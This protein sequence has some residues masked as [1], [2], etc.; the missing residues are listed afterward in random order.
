MNFADS[1][2]VALSHDFS[3]I[4]QKH[5]QHIL[6]SPW[7][8]L[9]EL[10]NHNGAHCN[11]SCPTQAWSMSTLLDAMYDLDLWN[12]VHPAKDEI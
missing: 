12:A 7:L 3:K 2:K 11:D 1:D 8:G 10:T 9:P 6:S 5:K 4:L